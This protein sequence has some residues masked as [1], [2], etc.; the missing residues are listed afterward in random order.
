MT[1]D[2]R[3]NPKTVDDVPVSRRLGLSEQV[4]IGLVLGI[5]AGIF[6][7]EMVGWLKIV[8]DVFIMLLQITVIP[9]ISFAL[10]T[11]LGDLRIDE[12]KRLALKG[13]TVVLTIWAITLVIILLT[14][15]SFPPGLRDP[16][17]ASA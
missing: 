14:P 4:L 1:K 6:F 7:G 5:A 9:Y 3:K 17:S 15:L 12:V 10:I 2:T 16:F 13:G 11:G 8:G